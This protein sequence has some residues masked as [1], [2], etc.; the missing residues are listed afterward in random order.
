[1]APIFFLD[2]A[3][4]GE[5]KVDGD[6]IFRQLTERFVKLVDPSSVDSRLSLRHYPD[7]F[8]IMPFFSTR[9]LFGVPSLGQ[10]AEPP[11]VSH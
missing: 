3:I 6:S 7:N 2:N 9:S 5:D 4:A 11:F 10:S 8:A 1:M